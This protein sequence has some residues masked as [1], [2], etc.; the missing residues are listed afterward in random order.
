MRE[1]AVKE[2]VKGITYKQAQ[3]EDL[4]KLHDALLQELDLSLVE[5][6]CPE[7]WKLDFTEHACCEKRRYSDAVAVMAAGRKPKRTRDEAGAAQRQEVR[8]RRF[9]T[10][11]RPL[12]F[13]ALPS[14][15]E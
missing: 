11:W 2:Y 10:C 8:C 14:R 9:R 4:H 15:A 12:G 13:K 1:F 7:G 6:I 3:L 5:L